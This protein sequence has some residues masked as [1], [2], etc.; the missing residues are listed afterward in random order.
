MK[1]STKKNSNIKSIF[2]RIILIFS[3][4]QL[5]FYEILPAID[6]SRVKH[7]LPNLWLYVVEMVVIF[8]MSMLIY[9]FHEKSSVNR[10]FRL[11]MLL[12]TVFF[13]L[14]IAAQLAYLDFR[15]PDYLATEM[16]VGL[17]GVY[18]LASTGLL[19]NLSLGEFTQTMILGAYSQEYY[20]P[21]VLKFYG[22]DPLQL[23][24]TYP[25]P[26]APEIVPADLPAWYTPLNWGVHFPGWSLL[27]YAVI[28]L[29]GK[30]PLYEVKLVF[31]LN[32]LTVYPLYYLARSL[33]GSKS[34]IMAIILY[35][36]MPSLVLHIPW[37]DLTVLFPV[38]LATLLALK[39][40]EHKSPKN[41]LFM[42]MAGIVLSF[43]FLMSN[44]SLIAIIGFLV[45]IFFYKNL[46]KIK[47][48][49]GFLLY[50]CLI[51]F[52]IAQLVLTPYIVTY[53]FLNLPIGSIVVSRRV[54]ISIPLAIAVLWL[55]VKHV[56]NDGKKKLLLFLTG[57]VMAFI[58]PLFL[59]VA[60]QLPAMQLLGLASARH[61]FNSYLQLYQESQK[62]SFLNM[63]PQFFILF[64]VHTFFIMLGT[65][66]IILLLIAVSRR[67]SN[68]LG[69]PPKDY[70][71]FIPAVLLMTIAFIVI[72]R[73]ELARVGLFLVPLLLVVASG[74]AARL[75]EHFGTKSIFSVIAF[76][77]LVETVIYVVFG[78]FF[79]LRYPL[80]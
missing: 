64:N 53:P 19:M 5:L 72:V 68:Y 38:S 23:A 47:T 14:S 74:Q 61:D 26:W 7:L 10:L 29:F 34:G 11:P 48:T 75:E 21:I 55:S 17:E 46:P 50:C 44:P 73:I 62:F 16:R 8:L 32:A 20:N 1:S 9:R 63:P 22:I 78:Y 77:L 45:L 59:Q 3:F 41:I 49:N 4:A 79:E 30:D 52:L 58:I 28:F 76:I 37:W 25:L 42:M 31:I 60:M 71:P 67:F 56:G 80:V 40:T 24:R 35:L 66:I 51:V 33:Y 65:P 6:S 39:A 2:L 54:L 27:A 36:F 13:F 15:D 70:E 69:L 12:P 57:A 43:G 18:G